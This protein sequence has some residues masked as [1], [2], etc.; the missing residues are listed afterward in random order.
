MPQVLLDALLCVEQRIEQELVGYVDG[1]HVVQI[2][3]QGVQLTGKVFD[4][5]QLATDQTVV[6]LVGDLLQPLETLAVVLGVLRF[7]RRCVEVVEHHQVG[8]GQVRQAAHLLDALHFLHG[9]LGVEAG[10]EGNGKHSK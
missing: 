8:R 7:K 4:F 9:V 6:V 2:A 1:A 10:A 3:W 5:S